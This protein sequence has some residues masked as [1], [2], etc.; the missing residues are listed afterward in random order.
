M[1]IFVSMYMCVV[2]CMEQ[3]HTFASKVD[4]IW[5]MAACSAWHRV[6]CASDSSMQF[7]LSS[8]NLISSSWCLCSHIEKLCIAIF[9][10][11]LVATIFFTSS[12]NK[13]FTIK[14]SFHKISG[15]SLPAMKIKQLKFSSVYECKFFPGYQWHTNYTNLFCIICNYQV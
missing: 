13:I 4:S 10:N 8:C 6:K 5:S 11:M 2:G 3:S 9:S 7:I 1:C 14:F 12:T 15:K